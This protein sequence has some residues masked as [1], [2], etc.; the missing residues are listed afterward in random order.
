MPAS[1]ASTATYV[2]NRVRVGLG[3]QSP[4][5]LDTQPPTAW[6]VCIQ[7]GL[8]RLEQFL[9]V[10]DENKSERRR[11]K[12]EK[13]ACAFFCPSTTTGGTTWQT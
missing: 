5:P 12:K 7:P 11:E 2:Y 8:P 9:E 13:P 3:M 4:S 6:A 1:I 10:G